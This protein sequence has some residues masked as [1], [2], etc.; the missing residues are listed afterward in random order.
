MAGMESERIRE[1]A[2]RARRGDREAFSQIA[3]VLMNSVMA[4]TYKM[5]GDREVALDLTQ[6]SFVSAWENLKSFRGDARFESW[7]YR[8]AMNK[9]L[10]H[11]QSKK[12]LPLDEQMDFADE[13]QPGPEQI[14]AR[15]ELRDLILEFMQ[16]LPEQQRLAFELRFYRQ[17]P[18]EGV[19]QV[20]GKAL[21]TVKTNYREAIKKLREFAEKRGIRP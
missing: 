7:L 21:G 10:N 13:H 15:A 6:E 2:D 5:T 12:S 17:M 4:L 1:L 20:A 11:V 16:S 3:K 9:A 18:F 14:L 8:I 19:S